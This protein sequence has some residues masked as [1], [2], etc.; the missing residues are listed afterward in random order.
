MLTF[1][2]FGL[3]GNLYELLNIRTD[4]FILL[5]CIVTIALQ[6]LL[7]FKVKKV[8]IRLIPVLLFSTLTI[9]YSVL[10]FVS[11][12]GW[13]SFGYALASIYAVCLLLFC[14]VGWGIW[15][16]IRLIVKRKKQKTTTE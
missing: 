11:D 2:L 6:L 9:T 1:R 12:D 5:V 8:F 3:L 4:V 7:C 13:V 16:T 14:G 10:R 15:W